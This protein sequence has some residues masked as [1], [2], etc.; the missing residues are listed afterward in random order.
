MSGLRA[1][2][3]CGDAY[4]CVAACGVDMP[5]YKLVYFSLR[6]RGE[7]VRW[8]LAAADQ[9]YEDVRYNKETEWPFKKPGNA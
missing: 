3:M 8:V 5:Q 7:P 4:Y 6:G 2:V 9:Q 1:V